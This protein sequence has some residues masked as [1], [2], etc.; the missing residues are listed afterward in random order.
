MHPGNPHFQAMNRVWLAKAALRKKAPTPMGAL[1][2]GLIA[3]AIG[4]GAQSLFFKLVKAPRQSKPPPGEG[5]PEGDD[6]SALQA[7]AERTTADLLKRPAPESAK[8]KIAT[9]IHVLFGAMWGGL[10]GLARESARFPPQL[11]GAA[12]WMLGDNLLLPAF[13]LAAWPHRYSLKEHRYALGAHMAYGMSTAGSYALLRDLGPVPLS[14]VPAM[15]L[16][17]LWAFVL[18][19]PPGRLALNRQPWATR[20][21]HGTLV[22]KAALC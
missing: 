5:K 19:M 9:A 18:R 10:Y 8:P 4:A 13:R 21:I 20:F 7:M 11:F 1:F 14:T 3:G 6:V 16:L 2:R 15:A 17:Q 22:Q 12:V